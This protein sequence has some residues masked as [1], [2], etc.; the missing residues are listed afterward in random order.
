MRILETKRARSQKYGLAPKNIGVAVC[1]HTHFLSIFFLSN[2]KANTQQY[3]LVRLSLL[4]LKYR[5][6][7]R[8]TTDMSAWSIVGKLVS[9]PTSNIWTR[10]SIVCRDEV[11]F[12][13]ISKKTEI[14]LRES[15]VPFVGVAL[16]SVN[17]NNRF[18]NWCQ[19][20]DIPIPFSN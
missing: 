12:M 3:S 2:A 13:E 5:G 17:C 4:V 9:L 7:S 6:L 14:G 1:L 16:S 10:E 20:K 18:K 15:Y 19:R 8:G 11:L